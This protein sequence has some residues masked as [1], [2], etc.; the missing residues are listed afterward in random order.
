MKSVI[1]F[2][3]GR[4]AGTIGAMLTGLGGASTGG[5]LAGYYHAKKGEVANKE[6]NRR[7]GNI[8]LYKDDDTGTN[9]LSAVA[10]GI[11]IVGALTNTITAT[12][13]YNARD[14]LNKKN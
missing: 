5:P 2:Y 6:L 14:R 7:S 10:G 1:L 4:I 8:N 9:W 13:H 11:P 3:E 12:R